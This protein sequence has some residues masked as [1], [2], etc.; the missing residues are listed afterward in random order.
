MR[1]SSIA[2]ALL[3]LSGTGW[4]VR[5][6]F[7]Q[8]GC[9]TGT[10][11]TLRAGLMDEF[12]S[13]PD[14]TSRG[15]G[16]DAAFPGAA[17]KDFDDST[18]NQL[19]GHTFTGLPAGIVRAELVV[20]ARPAGSGSQNDS[21]DIGL[22]PPNH[23]ATAFQFINFREA[24]GTWDVGHNGPTTFTISLDSSFP[25]LLAQMSSTHALEILVQD[26]SEVD[27]MT[28]RVWTC[29]PPAVSFG[30]LH[31]ALGQAELRQDAQGHLVVS[32]LGASGE[33][34][35]AVPIGAGSDW[36][37]TWSELEAQ[38][39]L[40]QGTVL[41][42]TAVGVVNGLA[43]KPIGSVRLEQSAGA[44]QISADFQS[45]GAATY[46]FEVRKDGPQGELVAHLTGQ[47]GVVAQ[48][49]L[50]P[51][52]FHVAGSLP[53][54]GTRIDFGR[55]SE[56]ELYDD[57]KLADGTIVQGDYIC[58][59][60]ENPSATISAATQAEIRAR[61]ISSLTFVD[62]SVGLFGFEHRPLGAALL[63]A[64]DGHLTI[65]NSLAGD[66]FTVDVGRAESA[67]L[68]LAPVDPL[69]TAPVGSFL[70]ASAT[71]P[72]DSETDQ[73]LG[74]LTVTKQAVDKYVVTADFSDVQSPTQDI[75]IFN[76]G[77][78]VADF[79]G[80][81]GQVAG[82]AR[83]PTVLG[84][85]FLLGSRTKCFSGNWPPATT[86][87]VDGN[88]Y[89]GDELRVLAETH[90][91]T[92][93]YLSQVALRSSGI[94]DLTLV[95]EE[96]TACPT[97]E[98]LLQPAN[99]TCGAG[100]PA[101]FSVTASSASPL[102]YR[103]RR[104]GADLADGSRLAGSSTATLTLSSTILAQTGT[105]DVV[106]SNSCGSVVSAPALYQPGVALRSLLLN[107]AGDVHGLIGHGAF[108]AA[109]ADSLSASLFKALAFL[110]DSNA[111]A[112]ANRVDV[113]LTRVQAFIRKGTLTAAQGQALTTTATGVR[114]HF[115]C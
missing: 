108:T 51:R 69:A 40:P 44:V 102:S 65:A 50:F 113:F 84:K 10:P 21:I 43:G 23:F 3:V 33:D 85:L 2:L 94:P 78:L 67:H 68:T 1:Q 107:L 34:G 29:P 14:P 18:I 93:G 63:Q 86:F 45:V 96:T 61:G 55:A 46:T 41:S 73:P 27:S 103:W 53:T 19:I 48:T 74:K 36:K 89:V 70:E 110:H 92:I 30:L 87:L 6:A 91:G 25:S 111:A 83:W 72:F 95:A 22:M 31:S 81:L 7:A 11:Y 39:P 26:D 82:I 115:D 112:A 62:E 66:G 12:A 99:M 100:K 24:H 5:P 101:F 109:Q 106:V 88:P 8:A 114:S 71:G 37:G 80:H 49:S 104:D 58:I 15:A 76:A 54:G 59:I 75:Q 20:R 97:P 90:G 57:F 13:P 60:P 28:L 105:Y 16:L 79:P 38:G 4:I 9:A 35:L 56:T 98:I 32:N 47:S 42:A 52:F 77:Q 64:A 17:W